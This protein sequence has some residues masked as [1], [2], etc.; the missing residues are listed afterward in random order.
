MPFAL[1]SLFLLPFANRLLYIYGRMLH[2]LLRRVLLS[3]PTLLVIS[4]I[5]FG[6]NKCAPGDPVITIYGEDLSQGYDPIQKSVNYQLKAAHL[7]LDRPNFYC[8]LT[9]TAYPDTLYRIFPPERR[10]RLSR[11]AG[12]VNNWPI[13][14]QYESRLGTALKL[15]ER[16]PDSLPQKAQLSLAMSNF[17][18]IEQLIFLDTAR[19]FLRRIVTQ[20]PPDPAFSTALDSLETSITALQNAAQKPHFPGPAFYWY[21]FDNQYHNWI[22]GFFSGRLGVS[23]TSKKPVWEDLKA[24]L[25]PT[26][27]L[28]GFAILLAYLLAVPIGVRM[29]R[30]R[31]GRF[32]RFGKRLLLTLYA[33]PV[34]W[35]GGLLILCFAT[36]DAGLFWIK[37]IV[38]N[39]WN[40]GESFLLWMGRNAGKLILP[41]LTLLIHI[42]A[43]LTLQTRSSM[44]EVLNQDYIKTARAKGL[45]EQM[46]HNKHA[47]RNALFPLITIFGSVFPAIFAGSLV[48]EYLFNFPGMGTKTQGAFMDRDYPVLYAILM[49]AAALT[50]LGS[51]VAD[52]LYAWADPR[53]RFT[54]R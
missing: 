40:P 28:N 49:I 11:L 22:K 9:T 46:V 24:R 20:L 36:P 3:I 30:Y 42:L 38:V 54:K 19:L 37:G 52:A 47:L 53:V 18:L 41:I 50:I 27:T 44:L 6:L 51:L 26:L 39:A 35:L 10:Q 32:D 23:L 29:A 21:G 15:F 14:S 34:F 2:Y 33:F 43:M 1:C 17:N 13:V 31:N 48:I 45:S 12:Q 7:G 16:M 25:L 5:I 4:W 8:S